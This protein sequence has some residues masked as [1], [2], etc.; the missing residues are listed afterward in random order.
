M[1]KKQTKKNNNNNKKKQ[2]TKNNKDRK[3]QGGTKAKVPYPF[4]RIAPTPTVLNPYS[5]SQKNVNR[6][7]N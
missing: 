5:P 1:K 4:T 7:T 3:E 6:T 2:K